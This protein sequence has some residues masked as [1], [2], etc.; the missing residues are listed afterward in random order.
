MF[1]VCFSVSYHPFNVP[2]QEGLYLN[3]R[4]SSTWMPL[5]MRF[6]GLRHYFHPTTNFNDIPDTYLL[7]LY[8]IVVSDAA[9]IS[10]R[11]A[12]LP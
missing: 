6:T 2:L 8:F 11:H 3:S 7:G 12:T 5:S 4:L 10:G 1:T 9:V